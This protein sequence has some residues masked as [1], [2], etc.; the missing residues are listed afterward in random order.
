MK[1]FSTFKK[2]RYLFFEKH[3]NDANLFKNASF[4][5]ALQLANDAN[6][7]KNASF[8]YAL[9]LVQIQFSSVQLLSRVRLFATP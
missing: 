6:L 3:A 9:Q 4:R 1:L 8:R 5:Y 7:F 2:Y